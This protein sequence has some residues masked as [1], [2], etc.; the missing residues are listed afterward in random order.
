M[1]LLMNESYTMRLNTRRCRN[2]ARQMGLVLRHNEWDIEQQYLGMCKK[3]SQMMM[4][5]LDLG[6]ISSRHK[7]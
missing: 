1:K 2:K 7:C 3:D 5:R 4:S 6:K